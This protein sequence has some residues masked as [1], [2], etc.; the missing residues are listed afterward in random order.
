[1][2]SPT[3]EVLTSSSNP[4]VAAAVALRDRR[5]RERTGLTLVDGAREVRRALDAGV[6]VVEAFICEPLLAGAD[7]R[8]ALDRLLGGPAPL[9]RT[10][11]RVFAKLA[12]GERAEGI[13]AVVR[14]PSLELE[15]LSLP[16]DPL[17][18]R[19][20][21]RREARQPRC[22]PAHR[23]WGG[24]GR[25][26][27]RLAADRPVQPER[28]PGERR[29]GLRRPDRVGLDAG[30]AGLAARRAVSGSWRRGSTPSGCTP[31]PT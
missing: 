11:E 18:A 19:P 14:I 13:V 25:R 29:H 4:R 8:A 10:S 17:V 31:T 12:F 1:M 22:G 2:P 21:R 7:A 28:H 6:E 5:E 27:R 16:V 30:R 23:R 9:H 20:R 24:G 15:R 26:R 3:P